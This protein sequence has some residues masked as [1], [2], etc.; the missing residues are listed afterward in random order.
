MSGHRLKETY[1]LA[2]ILTI[3]INVQLLLE[4]I[5]LIFQSLGEMEITKINQTKF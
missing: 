1:N 4:L 3:K 2:I 5:I